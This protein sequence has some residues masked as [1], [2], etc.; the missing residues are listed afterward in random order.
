MKRLIFFS[1]VFGLAI[2]AA[3]RERS[4]DERLAQY[5]ASVQERLAPLF[6]ASGVAYPPCQV[7][8]SPVD[9]RVRRVPAIK[10]GA[11][12]WVDALYGS[13]KNELSLYKKKQ[14]AEPA[15]AQPPAAY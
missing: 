12:P 13:I 8:L 6:V 10:A 15:A 2:R 3:A 11:P 4:V 9:F 7:I 14:N 5:G 1:I